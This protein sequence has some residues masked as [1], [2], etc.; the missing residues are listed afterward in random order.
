[1]IDWIQ[2]ETHKFHIRELHTRGS[3]GVRYRVVIEL[4]TLDP[5]KSTIYINNFNTQFITKEEA[6]DHG[7]RVILGTSSRV[8]NN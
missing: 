2:V 5:N 8:I 7:Y 3:D 6:T 1:M 4:N